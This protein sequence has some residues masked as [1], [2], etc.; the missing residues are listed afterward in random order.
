MQGSGGYSNGRSRRE[1]FVVGVAV[2]V[3]ALM[4]FVPVIVI[5]G[6]D[7]NHGFEKAIT[8]SEL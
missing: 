6:Q 7:K 8:S 5:C 1:A 3:V 4:N 2:T